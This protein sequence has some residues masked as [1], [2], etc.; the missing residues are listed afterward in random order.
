M[1]IYKKTKIDDRNP[2]YTIYFWRW[3]CYS[4]IIRQEK[5]GA[6]CERNFIWSGIL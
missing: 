3:L 2:K 6:A 1:E 5:E 4:V